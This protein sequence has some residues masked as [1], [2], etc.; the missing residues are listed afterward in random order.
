MLIILVAELAG[1]QFVSTYSRNIRR[2]L[3]ADQSVL[4]CSTPAGQTSGSEPQFP[5]AAHGEPRSPNWSSQRRP[6]N[7][8]MCARAHTRNEIKYIK[9]TSPQSN[10]QLWGLEREYLFHSPHPTLKVH[11]TYKI[12]MSLHIH[13][14]MLTIE[15]LWLPGIWRGNCM[16]YLN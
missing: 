7:T 8:E 4:P 3:C 2:L 10:K 16:L 1:W 15:T 9:A 13:L 6:A 12:I 11:K 14:S 5:A